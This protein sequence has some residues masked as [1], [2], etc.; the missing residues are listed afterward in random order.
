M[1]RGFFSIVV[2]LGFQK[3]PFKK[4]FQATINMQ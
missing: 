2:N 1:T 4:V 3:K